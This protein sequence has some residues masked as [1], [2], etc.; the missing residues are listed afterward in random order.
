[1]LSAAVDPGAE[2]PQALA[3]GNGGD[4]IKQTGD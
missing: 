2:A 3:G 4:M 1:L